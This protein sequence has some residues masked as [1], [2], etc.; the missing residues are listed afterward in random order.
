MKKTLKYIFVVI[1]LSFII[2]LLEDL[3]H[4]DVIGEYIRAFYT[5]LGIYFLAI[6]ICGKTIIR[7]L[8]LDKDHTYVCPKCKKKYLI[9]A[10]ICKI[11]RN[12][13]VSL[14]C[15]NCHEKLSRLDEGDN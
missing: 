5:I 8:E 6:L 1:A 12:V 4:F 3:V 2:F 9:P 11:S 10:D 15:K 7:F 14:R 13:D